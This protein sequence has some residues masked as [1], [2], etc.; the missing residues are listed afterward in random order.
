MPVIWLSLKL[1]M[2]MIWAAHEQLRLGLLIA[3]LN[4]AQ[5]RN[6]LSSNIFQSMAYKQAEPEHIF[7]VKIMEKLSLARLKLIL[8]L[9]QAKLEQIMW[10]LAR[11]QDELEG[12][13]N[14]LTLAE[15]PDTC[16]SLA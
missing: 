16:V 1:G 15:Q 4:S 13:F 3:C 10:N 11:V 2:Q 5:L 14:T 9:S 8:K 12:V 6:K 7:H